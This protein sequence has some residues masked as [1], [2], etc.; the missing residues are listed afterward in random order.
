M[1]WQFSGDKP[2]FQQLNERITLEILTGRYA[3]GDKL[4][5]V[6]ELAVEAGVNPN[7]VQRA[8]LEAETTGLLE[9]RRGDGRYVTLDASV[10]AEA[11]RRYAASLTENYLRSLRALKLSED[12]IKELWKKALSS[13]DS[14]QERKDTI[15]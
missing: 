9:T 2:I 1:A 3:P 5:T 15:S 4:P 8:L 11:R 7:T 6:R 10:I 14:Q 13:C 12:A